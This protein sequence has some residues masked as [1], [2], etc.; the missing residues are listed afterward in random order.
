MR[1]G[2]AAGEE[3]EEQNSRFQ[4]RAAPRQ[5]EISR[6]PLSRLSEG[7]RG[8]RRREPRRSFE[9]TRPLEELHLDSSDKPPRQFSLSERAFDI[10]R[11]ATGFQ[12]DQC[13]YGLTDNSE[14]TRR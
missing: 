9:V 12:M 13:R 1:D 2:A 10:D 5:A 11:A 14:S 6:L 4:S 8:V 3:G 7:E